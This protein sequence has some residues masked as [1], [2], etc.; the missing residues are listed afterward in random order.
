MCGLSL[1][2]MNYYHELIVWIDLTCKHINASN[3]FMVDVLVACL[4]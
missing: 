2:K 1:E 4:W 3:T